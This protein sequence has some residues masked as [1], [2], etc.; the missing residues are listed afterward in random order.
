[1]H[2]ELYLRGPF[3]FRWKS[4]RLATLEMFQTAQVSLCYT[5]T[6]TTTIITTITNQFASSLQ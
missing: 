6:T 5:T 1:M 4:W 2:I 3:R